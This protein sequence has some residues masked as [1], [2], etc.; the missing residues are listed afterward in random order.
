[1]HNNNTDDIAKF[2]LDPGF[3]Q[4]LRY[5]LN[6]VVKS[7]TI[8][9]VDGFMIYNSPRLTSKFDLKL[10]VRAP[11]EVLKERRSARPGYQT[12]DS[13][14]VDPPYYFDEFVYDSY[15]T[16]HAD[17]FIDGDVE[18]SLNPQTAAGIKDFNN[19]SQTSLM[20]ALSWATD[21]IC[22]AVTTAH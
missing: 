3:L 14:W 19:D 7:T 5:K 12:L 20:E 18:G 2:N 1:M 6:A 9:L 21:E 16:S 11:Y 13:Y 8:V 4:T 17:L 22:N 15:K 10:F